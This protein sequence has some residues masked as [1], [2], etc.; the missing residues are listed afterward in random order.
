M[1]VFKEDG[2]LCYCFLLVSILTCCCCC[3][4]CRQEAAAAGNN[5][6]LSVDH[7]KSQLA[8]ESAS[9]EALRQGQAVAA[10]NEAVVIVGL[11]GQVGEL[12]SMVSALQSQLA[13]ADHARRQDAATAEMRDQ[14]R[15][16]QIATAES[17]MLQRC[18]VMVDARAK[19]AEGREQQ[20][21]WGSTI[22][23]NEF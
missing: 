5:L 19:E 22:V 12:Q 18:A 6:H 15:Q 13:A 17:N 8:S 23:H 1:D 9:L 21:R 7:L 3:C 14:A 16:K 20:N 11:K 4:C 10:Q 2:C